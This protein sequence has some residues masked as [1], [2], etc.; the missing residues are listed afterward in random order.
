MFCRYFWL[1]YT[2]VK[3]AILLLW[4]YLIVLSF[5]YSKKGALLFLFSFAHAKMILMVI[6]NTSYSVY[7]ICIWK[8]IK[9]HKTLRVSQFVILGQS[10]QDP[11]L[12]VNVLTA[13]CRAS[14]KLKDLSIC[15]LCLCL[16]NILCMI[17]SLFCIY[18]WSQWKFL[19]SVNTKSVHE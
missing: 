7:H 6:M 11:S 10:P 1:F 5:K 16:N 13:F 8:G 2:Y 19:A 17:V 12:C 15:Y 3:A 18:H 14:W 9:Y 4:Y